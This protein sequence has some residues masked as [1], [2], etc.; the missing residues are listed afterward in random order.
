MIS[1]ASASEITKRSL[2]LSLDGIKIK[3]GS[4][5]LKGVC[6]ADSIITTSTSSYVAGGSPIQ[7]KIINKVD[8]DSVMVYAVSRHNIKVGSWIL[9]GDDNFIYD[10]GYEI[11]ER[12]LNISPASTV[13][14]STSSTN[15]GVPD[16]RTTSNNRP[17]ASSIDSSVPH[18]SNTDSS[19]PH[20]S[21]TDSGTPDVNSGV[22]GASSTSSG[23]PGASSTSSGTP[24]AIST[25]YSAP[26]TS[27]TS[28]A[29]PSTSNT[30]YSTPGT[31]STSS[32]AP[33]AS[34][35]SPSVP[36]ASNS[37]S[38]SQP[39]GGSCD[40]YGGPTP[41]PLSCSAAARKTDEK[42]EWAV[43]TWLLVIWVGLIWW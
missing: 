23:T 35:I 30:S 7:V 8:I 18:A 15:S 9:N 28:S 12:H 39:T 36:I 32:N 42:M 41:R 17:G 25:S 1:T 3:R 10:A 21:S 6:F 5:S 34:S 14:A 4:T 20:A 31:S 29:T 27:S 24:G 38:Q 16:V 19:I 2:N 43:F 40:L 33:D 13:I 26:D 37:V 11:H 22:S